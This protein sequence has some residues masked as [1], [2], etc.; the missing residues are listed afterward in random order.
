[1]HSMVVQDIEGFDKENAKYIFQNSRKVQYP[2]RIE[3]TT[4]K[5][6][7]YQNKEEDG[8][9]RVFKLEPPQYFWKPREPWVKIKI[10]I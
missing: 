9:K 8:Q 10:N 5:N 6:V 4:I 1:M 7:W 2:W 3:I